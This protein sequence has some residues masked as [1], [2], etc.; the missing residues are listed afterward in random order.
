MYYV[1]KILLLSIAEGMCDC[2]S[3]TYLLDI[4]YFNILIHTISGFI[5]PLIASTTTHQ[6]TSTSKSKTGIIFKKT[7]QLLKSELRMSE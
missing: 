3:N 7:K 2:E 4:S 6:C 5:S 1:N